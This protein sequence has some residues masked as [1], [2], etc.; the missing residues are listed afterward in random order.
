MN[1]KKI[2]RVLCFSIFFMIIPLLTVSASDKSEVWKKMYN[3]AVTIEQ[4]SAIMQNIVALD[5]PELIELLDYALAQQI[6]SLENQMNRSEHEKKDQLMRMIVNELSSLKAEK[7]AGTIFTLF[8][9]VDNH[10]LKADCLVAL[11]QI[12]AVDFVPQISMVLRNLNFN[13]A[14][15][16]S[17]A[18]ILAYAAVVSLERMRDVRGFEQVFYA[19][20]GWYSRRITNKAVQVLKVISEDPSEP[21]LK[22]LGGESDYTAKL[23][24]LNVENES[25]ASSENKNKVAA[26]GLNEGLRYS[27]IDKMEEYQLSKLRQAAINMLIIYQYKGSDVVNDLIYNYERTSDINDKLLTIQALGVNASIEAVLWMSN[28]L[29]EYNSRQLSGL[30]ANQTELIYVKQLINSLALTGNVNAKTVLMEVQ[31]SDYTPAIVR[32]VKEALTKF[33]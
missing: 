17:E 23:K 12:R 11:G 1:I 4:Q 2:R 28:V 13:M 3:R 9:S 16:P 30:S 18:E 10:I 19:S 26:F 31:F 22:I 15:E 20:L 32:L 7:S 6:S 29:S 27:A 24:A 33:E 21:I 5:D 25:N 14:M 8:N